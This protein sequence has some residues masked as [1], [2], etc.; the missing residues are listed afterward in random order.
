MLRTNDRGR[1]TGRAGACGPIRPPMKLLLRLLAT[2]CLLLVLTAAGVVGHALWMARAPLPAAAGVIIVLGGDMTGDNR[3][4]GET[5]GR[6][7]AGVRLYQAGAAPRIHFTGGVPADGRPGAG[8]QMRGLAVGIG[9]PPAAT[10]A[11]SL[12][13]STLQNALFSRPILGPRADGPVILVSDGF[14]LARS[15]LSFRWAGY[16]QVALAAATPF[17]DQPRWRQARRVAREAL[18][19]WF[20]LARIGAWETLDLVSGPDADRIDMLR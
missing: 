7:L 1:A 5:R 6:V 14:H 16:P 9:V 12:S 2:G 10:S 4:A 17:G 20:N 3:L 15:W 18:A 13:R 11:E 19:W 8:E